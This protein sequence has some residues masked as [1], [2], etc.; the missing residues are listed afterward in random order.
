MKNKTV[1]ILAICLVISS[2]V[3]M[4]PAC[5][6]GNE[7]EQTT[8]EVT[9]ATPE[10]T[11]T[12]PDNAILLFDGEKFLY[13]VVRPEFADS[14]IVASAVKLKMKFSTLAGDAD[15]KLVD[16]FLK[17][18]EEE[19][20]CEIIV[21]DADRKIIKDLTD[22]MTVKEN[23]EIS[24]DANGIAICG[25]TNVYTEKGV[26]YFCDV[27]LPENIVKVGDKMYI[28]C[29]SYSSEKEMPTFGRYVE[30]CLEEKKEISFTS[31]LYLTMPPVNTHTILQGGCVD[32][33]GKYAYF[34]FQKNNK[35]SIAKYD[36]EKKELVDSKHE[37]LTDHSNDACYNPKLNAVI[38]VH[39]A[40]NYKLISMFDADTLER[41]GAPKTFSKNI[42]SIAYN[43]ATD[44]YIV[45]L[46]G[47][48]NFAIL[49]SNFKIIEEI[50]GV[51]TGYTRQGVDADDEY[52]YFVQSTGSTQYIVIY[53]WNGDHVATL[54]LNGINEEVEHAFHI[55]NQLYISCYPGSNKG[56]INYKININI[57]E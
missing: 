18:G 55:G 13:N 17:K 44:R 57:E 41:I 26:D 38:V 49:D 5:K 8:P 2:L 31:E 50:N 15:V 10:T 45:G 11:E 24:V 40:P 1:R 51:S 21:G 6:G 14:R 36:F 29:G 28:K 46:S 37:I 4:L 7:N 12:A 9:T 20:K 22:K 47:D 52:I 23:F 42:Y 25:S 33:E 35:S 53:K 56:G 16:D 43:E 19:P 39:N 48:Y 32:K 30:F 27:F 34:L 3:C 54:P